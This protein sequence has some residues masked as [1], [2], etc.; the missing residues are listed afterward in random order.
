MGL[1][2]R[3]DGCVS[4][5]D[6][7]RSL[8]PVP[9]YV[10]LRP[11]NSPAIAGAVQRCRVASEAGTDQKIRGEPG[12]AIR[13]QRNRAHGVMAM[14]ILRPGSEDFGGHESEIRF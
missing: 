6:V 4:L 5:R 11:G 7:A 14:S 10:L 13:A 2:A 3:P 9:E 1:V 12:M 8:S